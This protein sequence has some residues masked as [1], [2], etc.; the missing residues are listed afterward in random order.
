MFS[1]FAEAI[2]DPDLRALAVAQQAW[3]SVD[4]M[5]VHTTVEEAYR[6]IGSLL[7]KLAPPDATVLVH[8]SKPIVMRFDDG[9]RSRLA[10]GMQPA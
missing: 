10:S 6:L 5:H 2:T 4:A 1:D 9:V 3:L 7:A 8:P